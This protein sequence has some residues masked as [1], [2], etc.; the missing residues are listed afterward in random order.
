MS[1]T[2][3]R[4]PDNEVSG[5]RVVRPFDSYKLNDTISAADIAKWPEQNWKAMVDQGMVELIRRE[6]PAASD[7]PLPYSI[8]GALVRV[9]VPRE[10]GRFDVVEGARINP[11]PLDEAAAEAL[12]DRIADAGPTVAQD[13][14]KEISAIE[15]PAPEKRTRGRRKGQKDVRPRRSHRMTGAEKKARREARAAQQQEA[16][17][18]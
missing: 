3:F 2:R 10:D 1:S 12:A 11:E 8:G 17:T 4:I 16:A 14:P 15:Q 18:G 7:I 9:V 13:A 5:A 6:S